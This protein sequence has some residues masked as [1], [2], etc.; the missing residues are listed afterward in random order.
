[1]ENIKLTIYLMKLRCPEQISNMRVSRGIQNQFFFCIYQLR[2]RIRFSDIKRMIIVRIIRCNKIIF[3]LPLRHTRI[4]TIK[5]N[6]KFKM[7][8]MHVSL[9]LIRSRHCKIHGTQVPIHSFRYLCT[10]CI[11]SHGPIFFQFFCTGCLYLLRELHTTVY[12]R[13]KFFTQSVRHAF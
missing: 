5:R 7:F 6:R 4:G 8:L 12:R 13:Q 9:Y 1:M 3:I 10:I 2:N 11:E